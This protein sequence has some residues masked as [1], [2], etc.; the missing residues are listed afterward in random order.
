MKLRLE[1]NAIILLL[2]IFYSYLFVFEIPWSNYVYFVDIDFY[3]DRIGVLFLSG[4]EGDIT[5]DYTG[6]GLLTSEI[7]WYIILIQ[8]PIFFADINLGLEFI[9]FISLVVYSYFTFKNSNI[10]FSSILLLNPIFIDLIM[11]QIR[12]AFAFALLLIAY[13][14]RKQYWFIS[15]LLLISSFMIHTATYL[16][17]F[18]YFFISLISKKI[19]NENKLH[20]LMLISPIFYVFFIRFLLLPLLDFF[21]D[22]GRVD[23][24]TGGV[25]TS[26][27]LFSSIY[28][29][30]ALLIAFLP[31]KND[32]KVSSEATNY[33]IFMCSLFFGLSL[34]QM[35]GSR[36]VAISFPF[37]IIAINNLQ[38]QGRLLLLSLLFSYQLIYIS[39]WIRFS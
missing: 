13:S 27:L 37:L 33:I 15:L 18:V 3:L 30:F 32:S 9:S 7:L 31:K 29:F 34:A 1:S 22:A 21:R 12:I 5:K 36:F 16:L 25:D 35:Y 19:Q 10:F 11:S 28:L 26:S 6:V 14:L 8:I 24:F 39:Y 23:Y 17:V 20:G 4:I 38:F 2:S